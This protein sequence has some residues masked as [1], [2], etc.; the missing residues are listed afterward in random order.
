MKK[1]TIFTLAPVLALLAVGCSSPIA[2]QSSEYDDMY[3]SST[4]E[5]VYVQ[6]E[7]QQRS[8][9][10]YQDYS[11]NTQ[12]QQQTLADGEVLNPEYSDNAVTQNYVGD[13]EYYD[14]RSYDARDNWYR[15]DYSF[16]DPYWGAAYA[17]RRM[18]YAY[19]DPFYDPFYN[20]PF[21]YDPFW[22]NARYGRGLSVS[23][24]YGMGWGGFYGSP[25]YGFSNWWPGS[26]GHG[27]YN[28]YNR[29]FNN[30][31]YASNPYNW[32]SDRPVVIGRASKVQYGPRDSRGSV[33]TNN[34]GAANRRS[35]RGEAVRSER[36]ENSQ[37]VVG[38]QSRSD[39][40][41]VAP[42]SGTNDRVV[43]PARPSRANRNTTTTTQPQQQR[44]QPAV[45]PTENSGR[46]SRSSTPSRTSEQP[47][48]TRSV[49]TSRPARTYESRPAT[50]TPATSTPSY[51]RSSSG[52][53]SSGTSSG[54]SSGGRSR[55][56]NN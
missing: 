31:Y 45:A 4:D 27:Y 50:S 18:S 26:Y 13:D 56:G 5:T 53:S 42:A 25:R 29:G 35:A 7:T 32:Y 12:Q 30:G 24:S 39:R 1:Y 49:E 20:D 22:N 11:N 43:L 21:Y 55:R 17:P 16:V 14:G 37:G 36:T 6:P 38:R 40:S 19:Y 34:D 28:G 2:M 44:T 23:I 52:S 33:V 46:R 10:A 41:T 15:P 8:E 51:Q 47:V 3:Y 9:Q 54:S 48:R